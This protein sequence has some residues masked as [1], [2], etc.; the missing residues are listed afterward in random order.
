[1]ESGEL[2]TNRTKKQFGF[3]L[4]ELLVVIAIL[5]LLLSILLPTLK[6]ATSVARQTVCLSNLRQLG[7]MTI[8]YAQE[9][10]Q[11][12]LPS[13]R[14]SEPQLRFP[15]NQ[16]LSLGGPPWYE[17]LR[18]T[19]DLDYSREN[20]SLLH[21]PSD[22]REKGYCSYSSNRYLMGFS[23]PRNAAEKNFPVRKLTSINGQA[24]KLILLGER[25][26]VEEGDIGKVDGQ[27]SMAGISVSTF[28]GTPDGKQLDN[29]GFYAG[30]H[31]RPQLIGEGG[32]TLVSGL[33]Q[34]FLTLDGHVELY[35]GELECTYTNG[36]TLDSWEYDTFSVKDSP[37]GS[38]PSLNRKNGK[39]QY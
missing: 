6:L 26:C 11:K 37:G 27:W 1:M 35:K 31:G 29:L 21:C 38:W 28:L 24:G 3:T 10:D 14:N 20:A 19:Q 4:V 34:P 25:G 2:I 7:I 39:S 13:A 22:R 9:N 30:R 32:R 12:I 17:L 33:K 23:S 15:D 18:Q 8:M 36:N 5:A 16:D